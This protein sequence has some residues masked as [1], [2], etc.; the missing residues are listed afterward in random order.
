MRE[1]PLDESELLPLKEEGESEPTLEDFQ[2]FDKESAKVILEE[3]E[4]E[5]AE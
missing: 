5:E 1:P 2:V 3:K 4:T